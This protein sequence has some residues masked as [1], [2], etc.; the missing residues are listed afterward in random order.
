MVKILNHSE[1][2][3]NRWRNG[4]YDN[5]KCN[6]VKGMTPWNK[7]KLMSKETCEKLR[8]NHLGKPGY[9]TGKCRSEETKSKVSK[10]LLGHKSTKKQL[11][12][13]SLCRIKG[14][15]KGV[16][17]I[18]TWSKGRHLT[19]EQRKNRR[20]LR[21]KQVEKVRLQGLPLMPATGKYEKEIL[22]NLEK[23]I[24][25]YKF[26]RQHKVVGYFIDGYCPALNLAVEVDEEYHKNIRGK[27]LVRENDIKKELSCQFLRIAVGGN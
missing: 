21:I 13:L 23:N 16:K 2:I 15:N 17:G 25:P 18:N 12:A 24:Y 14:H 10:S 8:L 19:N 9:W 3:K 4:V 5:R 1:M 26:F 20:L 11:E 27:D 22:D 6:F 7:G